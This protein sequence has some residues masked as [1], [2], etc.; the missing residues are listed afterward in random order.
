MVSEWDETKAPLTN[1]LR[2][3]VCFCRDQVESNQ[4]TAERKNQKG[5]LK[6]QQQ[7]KKDQMERQKKE[8]EFK[9]IFQV[10]HGLKI[11]V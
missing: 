5:A 9:K 2:W 3:K 4:G 6:Q 11:Q 7:E 1:S 10:I 8:N